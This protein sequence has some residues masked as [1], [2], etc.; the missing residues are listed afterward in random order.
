MNSLL[1]L[2]GIEFAVLLILCLICV[3]LVVIIV[4]L[5][6]YYRAYKKGVKTSSKTAQAQP[7]YP[8]VIREVKRVN[9]EKPVIEAP[10]KPA[11]EEPEEEEIPTVEKE[12]AFAQAAEAATI[13]DAPET[14]AVPETPVVPEIPVIP[15]APVVPETPVV[16]D[17]SE[18]AMRY[19]RSFRARIIQSDDE[20]KEWYGTLKNAILSYDRVSS[21]I[22]WKY[23]S[24][25]YRRNAVAKIFVKGKTL[26]LYLN[27]NPA[28]YAETK[29]K[30]DDVAKIAQFA[31]T[32]ALYKLKSQK[33]IRYALDLIDDVCAKKL[34]STKLDR[35]PV[36]YYEPYNSDVA[37]I[38]KGLVKRVIEDASKSFIGASGF[39]KAQDETT[40]FDSKK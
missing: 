14:P 31:D 9:V 23:E 11:A 3:A 12:I 28:D 36:D 21:R 1:A 5:I 22:S 4:S 24:F 6:F 32:P 7:V 30:L 15:E 40:D 16:A 38:K 17:E 39:N 18:N 29:Y 37:L 13:M 34:G 33:R 27:L 20:V 19:N 2:T 26:Y 10:A 25:A 8:I 35:E